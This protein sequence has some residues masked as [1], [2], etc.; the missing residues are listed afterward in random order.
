MG[1][2]ISSDPNPQAR[3]RLFCFPY[4]GGGSAR[5]YPWAKSLPDT[6]DICPI[7]LP[8]REVR[9]REPCITHIDELL[10]VLTA[11]LRPHLGGAFA[12]FGHSMGGMIAF[13]LAHHLKS[14]DL[15]LPGH[16]FISS[17]RPPLSGSTVI[18]R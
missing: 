12:F 16:L 6:I 10:D 15:P 3:L 2:L 17:T 5:F 14:L 1:T 11:G 13:A 4:A 9:R 7:Q 18:V 8:G